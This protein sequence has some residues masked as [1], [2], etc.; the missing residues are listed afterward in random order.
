MEDAKTVWGGTAN[1]RGYQNEN[2]ISGNSNDTARSDISEE[3]LKLI[4]IP[5]KFVSIMTHQYVRYGSEYIYTPTTLFDTTFAHIIFL[6]WRGGCC[7]A[8]VG[9]VAP[10]G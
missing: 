7:L 10:S 4:G 5:K 3:F 8:V 9:K 2:T 1:V 6:I